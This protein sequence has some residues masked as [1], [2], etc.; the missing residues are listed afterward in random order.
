[1][2]ERENQYKAFVVVQLFARHWGRTF[3][4]AG[5]KSVK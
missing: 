5:A 2:T 3:T 4:A 1:M